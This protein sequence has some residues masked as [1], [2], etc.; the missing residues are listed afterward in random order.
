VKN[1]QIFLVLGIVAMLIGIFIMGSKIYKKSEAERLTTTMGESSK[2]FVPD[3]APKM[4][5]ETPQVYLVEFLDPE[6][7]SCREF[8]PHVKMIMK[9]Y[10]G[11]VQLVIRYAPFHGNSRFAIKILEA[12]R[13]QGKYWETLELLFQYQPQWGSHHNPQ[14][15]LVWNYLPEVGLDIEK[16]KMDM[17]DP[18]IEAMIESEIK[19]GQALGVRGTPSFFVNGKPLEIF[20]PEG[21]RSLI[22]ANL[23]AN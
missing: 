6:C 21:L 8:S 15:E 1:K 2:Q 17:N 14:P 22:D 12:A 9:D 19:D 3:Y 20:S 4:G 23:S 7:E 16:I 18:A 13:K 11:K 10:E 5:T